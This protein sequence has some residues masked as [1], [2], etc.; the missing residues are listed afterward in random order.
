MIICF[1]FE[2]TCGQRILSKI[3]GVPQMA[4]RQTHFWGAHILHWV[5]SL[6]SLLLSTE[7]WKR[8]K[9][10]YK[11]KAHT[12]VII[13]LSIELVLKDFL[14]WWFCR[15]THV[16]GKLQVS[17]T[18]SSFNPLS[19]IA[20]DKREPFQCLNIVL[21]NKTGPLFLELKIHF[22]F[23][24]RYIANS[25]T[26]GRTR[27]YLQKKKIQATVSLHTEPYMT[28]GTFHSN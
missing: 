22:S 16:A 5:K 14:F 15:H 21:N 18:F 19:S 1:M 25:V 8:W 12:W 20:I 13:S 28:M 7:K 10:Q 24:K 23:L 17:P 4:C 26:N 2:C 3:E 11:F 9:S 27:C 6:L